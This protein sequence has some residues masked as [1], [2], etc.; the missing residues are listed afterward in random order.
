M[1]HDPARCRLGRRPA[2]RD[3]RLF[4]LAE[5][6][7]SPL[8]LPPAAKDWS[9]AVDNWGQMLNDRMGDCAIAGRGH[10]HQ[11]RTALA[12]HEETPTDALIEADYVAVTGMEGAAYDPQTGANDNGCVLE[13]VLSYYRKKAEIGAYAFVRPRSLDHLRFTIDAFESAY[14]GV[15]LPITAQHQQVW[16]VVD[17]GLQGDS[18]V[19]SWGGH[20][21]VLSGYDESGFTCVT[22]GQT[23]RL[24]TAWWLAYGV[25]AYAVLSP[26]MIDGAGN[27][28]SGFNMDALRADLAAL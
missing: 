14:V 16:D 12:G 18:S 10:Q 22:W 15:D 7:A 13:D 21:I 2:K 20:C 24:T 8:P 17:P 25:E 27:V 26:E 3:P 1:I 5:Y 23:K 6:L 4:L 28:P 19:G 11:L 9:E